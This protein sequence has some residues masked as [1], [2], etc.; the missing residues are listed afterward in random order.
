M[1]DIT[2]GG[3]VFQSI[4]GLREKI[5]TIARVVDNDRNGIFW[6]PILSDEVH[7]LSVTELRKIADWAE[8]EEFMRARIRK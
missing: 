4:A 6:C 8:N 2:I 5:G 7:P 1:I 3:E